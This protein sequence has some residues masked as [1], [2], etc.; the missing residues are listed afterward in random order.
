MSPLIDIA[1]FVLCGFVLGVILMI[2]TLPRMLRRE[3]QKATSSMLGQ[4]LISAAVSKNGC[5]C[6]RSSAKLANQTT[7]PA[8]YS[9]SQNSPS[10]STETAAP[11][12]V[13]PN[14]GERSAQRLEGA[15]CQ[16]KPQEAQLCN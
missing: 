2:N 13:L 11:N 3:Q 6:E 14:Q 12:R 16:A 10:T 15:E 5:T 8:E 1:T 9:Q 7:A 4:M